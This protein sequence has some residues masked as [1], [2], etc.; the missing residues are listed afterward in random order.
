VFGRSGKEEEQST[1]VKDRVTPAKKET[2][3]ESKLALYHDEILALRRDGKTYEAIAAHLNQK[4]GAKVQSRPGRLVSKSTVH[5][6][7]ASVASPVQAAVATLPPDASNL[8]KLIVEKSAE[9]AELR[10]LA[11]QSREGHIATVLKIN[12]LTAL[13]AKFHSETVAQLNA[14]ALPSE[15]SRPLPSLPGNGTAPELGAL[16]SAVEELGKQIR[17]AQLV[18]D[19][20]LWKV[21]RTAFIVTGILWG[22]A[23]ALLR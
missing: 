22:V 6:Y 20:A 8:Q 3:G 2:S 19:A 18:P 13:L 4:Y 23:V 21:W 10:A 7:L 12:E 16:K 5:T 1:K 17:Q 14:M 9:L 11:E 15:L